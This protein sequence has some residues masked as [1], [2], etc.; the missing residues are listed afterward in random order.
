MLA[1][2]QQEDRYTM[3][4]V[5]IHNEIEHAHILSATYKLKGHIHVAN[6]QLAHYQYLGTIIDSKLNFEENCAAVCKKGHQ[7]LHCLRKLAFFNIDKTIMTLFYH[8]FIESILS[9]S[10][11]S[12]FGNLCLK[13]KNLLFQVVKWSSKAIGETQLH[14]ELLYTRQLQ[15]L[16]MAILEDNSQ[17]LHTAFQLLT[18]GRRFLVPRSRTVRL[19]KVLFRRQ[20]HCWTSCG[21]TLPCSLA[22]LFIYGYLYT[23]TWCIYS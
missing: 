16:A 6:W 4:I 10:L 5:Q 2:T 21:K 1:Y 11:V 13:N 3:K 7:W 9:F 17:P 22:Q 20:S 12:W 8:A 18:S 23:L 14:P 19:K 15:R